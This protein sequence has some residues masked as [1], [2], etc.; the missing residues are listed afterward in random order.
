MTM[1]E[2]IRSLRLKHGLTQEELGKHLGVQ[3]SAIRKYESGMV[4]N[5][6]LSS[7][8]KM[9][10]LFGVRPSYLMGFDETTELKETSN[11]TNPP[12][13]KDYEI[14]K[15]NFHQHCKHMALAP[16]QV[17]ER[18]NIPASEYN[19]WSTD[20]LPSAES[21]QK[22]AKIFHVPIEHLI[23]DQEPEPDQKGNLNFIESNGLHFVPVYE[24][25]SA[26]FG[27][28]AIDSIQDYI[29]TF[30]DDPHEATN[31]LCIRV[32]GDSMSPKIEDGDLIQVRKQDFAEDGS[33]AVVM[34]DGEEFFVKKFFSGKTWV[35]LHSLNS[36]YKPM[37]FN[38]EDANRVQVV[39]IVKKIIKDV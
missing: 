29:P 6:P 14:F 15:N 35:E 19:Q 31:T 37:R 10:D 25:V 12:F 11:A 17:F 9:A 26:G 27:A 33:I 28:S 20:Y 3:K 7:I 34:L 5:I 22:L 2:N 8:Q 18:A 1:G 23:K 13:I 21:I 24:G 38:G 4:K 16:T 30:I 36:V 32:R 39:G